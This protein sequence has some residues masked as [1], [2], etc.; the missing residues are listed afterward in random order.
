MVMP[1]FNN[2]IDTNSYEAVDDY[3]LILWSDLVVRY[4]PRAEPDYVV[5]APGMVI[6]EDFNEGFVLGCGCPV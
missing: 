5:V 4:G 2:C 1:C 3:V 6:K